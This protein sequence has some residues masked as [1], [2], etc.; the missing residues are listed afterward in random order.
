MDGIQVVDDTSLPVLGTDVRSAHIARVD[1]VR[2]LD[3]DDAGP[4]RCPLCNI[5]DAL[6]IGANRS[7]FGLQTGPDRLCIWAVL[8]TSQIPG[9]WREHD[10]WLIFVVVKQS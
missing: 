2:I 4:D 7:P 6:E 5:D 3:V 1:G 8:A 9:R 10:S